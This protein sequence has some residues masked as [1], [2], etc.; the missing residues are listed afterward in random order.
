MSH[1]PTRCCLPRAPSPSSLTEQRWKL[2][3]ITYPAIIVVAGAVIAP[4]MLPILPA[5]T[6][7]RYQKALGYPP[8]EFEHQRNGRLPQ[9]F[10]EEFGWEDVARQTAIA[11]HRLSPED[12]AKTV[13]FA[14]NYGEAAAI[15]FFGPRYGLPKAISVH[16]NYWLWG[17]DH[18]SGDVV[19]V[20]GSDGAGDRDHFRSVEA[21]GRV[22]HPYSRLDEHYTIWL[23][24]GLTF[25]L[26]EMWPHLKKWS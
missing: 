1:P 15:N 4:I 11:F 2:A 21:A 5:E 7:I 26:H 18:A 12:Q 25:D 13:I 9:Y 23:C 14:N 6:Y 19:L 3:R 20:L 8:P 10:A 24:R 17:P 22:D 16:Q